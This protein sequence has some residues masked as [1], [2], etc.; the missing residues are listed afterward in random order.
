MMIPIFFENALPKNYKYKVTYLK[1][2][3]D[4]DI[5]K[6]P[7]LMAN[8]NVNVYALRLLSMI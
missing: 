5:L 6:E 1:M 3:E 7:R 2:L 4:S 8:F